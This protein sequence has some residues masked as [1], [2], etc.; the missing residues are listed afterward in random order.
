MFSSRDRLERERPGPAPLGVYELGGHGNGDSGCALLERVFAGKVASL[1]V[2]VRKKN[3][4]DDVL[5]LKEKVDVKEM[6]SVRPLGKKQC[7]GT[8]QLEGI[9]GG[10]VRFGITDTLVFIANAGLYMLA[11]G[12]AL[13]FIKSQ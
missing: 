5:H 7:G 8:V 1:E 9:H 6:S 13:Q 11:L 12:V 10:A 3:G 4:D 2:L